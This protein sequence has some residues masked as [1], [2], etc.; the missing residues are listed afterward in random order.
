VPTFS[1][2]SDVQYV[3]SKLEDD[4]DEGAG[5][6]SVRTKSR[7]TEEKEPREKQHRRRP[8]NE[9]LLEEQE[10]MFRRNKYGREKEEVRQPVV[11]AIPIS[12][13]KPRPV[14]S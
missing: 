12:K 6:E 11:P 14:E 5:Y 10:D 13:Y 3:R 1:N 9:E 2:V 8:S 4:F 7:Y